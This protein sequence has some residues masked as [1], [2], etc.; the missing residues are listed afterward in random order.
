MPLTKYFCTKGY[1]IMTGSMTTMM[2]AHFRFSPTSSVVSMALCPTA[3]LPRSFSV[4]AVTISFKMTCR[5]YR[6][7][8]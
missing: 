7:F 1:T 8:V 5:G 4:L 2:V 3:L 6:L